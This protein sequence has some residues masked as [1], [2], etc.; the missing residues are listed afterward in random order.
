MSE[1]S[2]LLERIKTG[3]GLDRALDTDICTHL[4]PEAGPCEPHCPGDEPIFWHDPLHKKP[5]PRLT[6]RVDS[7]LW[8]LRQ[9]LPGWDWR[10]ESPSYYL[11]L[12]EPEFYAV[13]KNTARSREARI[14]LQ[15]PRYDD[16]LTRRGVHA[17]SHFGQTARSEA[18]A[19][20]AA[21]LHALD[22]KEKNRG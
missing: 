21:V 11:D 5:P 9:V 8:L 16:H 18:R 22:M 12:A 20:L 15:S 19:L 2:S 4:F 10:L 13:L 1:L 3:D 17:Q 7:V 14:E 6:L